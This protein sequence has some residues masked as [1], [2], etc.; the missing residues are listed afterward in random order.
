MPGNC[1][2]DVSRARSI[3]LSRLLVAL[4]PHYSSLCSYLCASLL[5]VLHVV[6]AIVRLSSG[7]K[8]IHFD[9]FNYLL[10]CWLPRVPLASLADSRSDSHLLRLPNF[11]PPS[12]GACSQA[13][14]F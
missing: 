12:L 10:D 2:A 13:I 1:G 4:V 8:P 14:L 11:F 7:K 5:T 9:R 6:Y 3:G